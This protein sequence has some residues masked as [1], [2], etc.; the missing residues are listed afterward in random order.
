MQASRN[1]KPITVSAYVTTPTRRTDAWKLR[2]VRTYC[3]SVSGYLRE[4]GRSGRFR[5]ARH[6]EPHF[7]ALDSYWIAEHQ[8]LLREGGAESAPH[9]SYGISNC[10]SF[11]LRLVVN[12]QTNTWG[13]EE[14]LDV[15]REVRYSKDSSK[16]VPT[17]L[18][19][20]LEIAPVTMSCS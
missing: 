19:L 8:P 2:S 20:Q 14:C 3:R 1:E 10:A 15:R 13:L 17:F 16:G 12:L 18:L 11:P 5:R 9:P 7:F 6:V 4:T